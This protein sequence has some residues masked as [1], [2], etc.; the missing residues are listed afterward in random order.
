MRLTDSVLGILSR[1]EDL[2]AGQQADQQGRYYAAASPT[3]WSRRRC[4]PSAVRFT[5]TTG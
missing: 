3:A 1:V 2:T 5:D 4:A